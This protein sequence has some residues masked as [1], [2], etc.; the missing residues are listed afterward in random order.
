[1]IQGLTIPN[2]RDIASIQHAI[3]T[4][5]G[6]FSRGPYASLNLSM[7]VG[8]DGTSVLKN[9]RAVAAYLNSDRFIALNQ[10]HGT[11]VKIIDTVPDTPQ[12]S[13]F[14]YAGEADALI[15]NIPDVF[16]VIQTA[17]CQAVLMVDLKKKVVA[18]VHVGWRGNTLNIIAKTIQ[19]MQTNYNCN[20]E[21]I[22]VGIGP[23]LGPCCA[24][25][26]NY[27]SEIPEK[28]WGYKD[29][30]KRFDLWAISSDQ[31][32][33]AGIPR[34]QITVSGMCTKCHPE[35]FFSYRAS[36]VTGRFAAVVAIQ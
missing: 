23:S 12:A 27:R 10:V 5:Q 1:M 9:R 30:K 20:P 11:N 35:L 28:Y 7:S 36:K 29:Q 6:G 22:W 4:R 8:D 2:L 16:L 15:T 18:N 26:V 21:D 17:D 24:E 31:L 33:A 13:L 25:F 14:N 19:T 3:F 34:S 32:E